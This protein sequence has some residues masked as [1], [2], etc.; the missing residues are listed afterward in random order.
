[1]ACASRLGGEV[2]GWQRR[3]RGHLVH[4]VLD[5]RARQ[6][7]A[8]PGGPVDELLER[9]GLHVVLRLPH[10]EEGGRVRARRGGHEH[11][12]VPPR[13][14]PRR[15]HGGHVLRRHLAHSLEIPLGVGGGE[16]V[17]HP[18]EAAGG[19]LGR[20]GLLAEELGEP[21]GDALGDGCA[22]GRERSL[23]EGAGAGYG[24]QDLV[25]QRAGGGVRAVDEGLELGVGHVVLGL[26]HAQDRLGAALGHEEG[27]CVAEGAP[28]R[29]LRLHGALRGHELGDARPPLVGHGGRGEGVLDGEE[30]GRGDLGRRR[31]GSGLLLHGGADDRGAARG[32]AAR[33]GAGSGAG[34]GHL[35]WYRG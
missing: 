11:V 21:V 6:H 27:V 29:S 34:D 8:R 14:V 15:G 23:R 32:G 3:A 25:V 22:A 18:E 28:L 16:L 13:L 33:G 30:L 2:R 24:A 4:D 7:G 17:A 31:R 35:C 10:A 12:V 1:M 20:G 5:R 9:R 26:P 19:G